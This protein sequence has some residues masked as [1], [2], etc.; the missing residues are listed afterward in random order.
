MATDTLIAPYGAGTPISAMA[1]PHIDETLRRETA[2]MPPIDLRRDQLSLLEL[3]LNGGLSPLPGYMGSAECASVLSQYR[4]LNGTFWPLPVLLDV[5]EQAVKSIAAGA[6]VALRDPEGF[7]LAILDVEEVWAPTA[8]Q[9]AVMH[10]GLAEAGRP[11]AASAFERRGTHFVSG[12]LTGLSVPVR[13]DFPGLR[14]TPEE[15]RRSFQKRGWRRVVAFQIHNTVHRVQFEVSLR[16][17]MSL[18]ANLFL[19]LL[20]CDDPF[21]SPEY[22]PRVRSVQTVLSRYP[23]ASTALCLLPLSMPARDARA[24][25]LRAIVARNYGATHLIVGG[26][27]QREGAA[28][29]GVDL[30]AASAHGELARFSSEVGVEILPFPRMMYVEERAEYVREEEIPK[31]SRTLIM[32]G[33]EIERRLSGGLSIPEWAAFPEVIDELR[34]SRPPRNRR[35]FTV[36]FTGLSG[37]GKSTLARV[38]TTKLLEIGDRR[39]TLLDGD[40]VR[41]HLSNELGFSRAHRD[42]N[43]R[44]IGFVASEITKNNG[45]AICA[46]IAP[47][48]ETRR[49]VRDMIEP[50]GGFFEV[51][52]S[53]PLDVCE[54]R[55]RKGLYARA[56]AGLIPE[57]TGVSDPYELPANPEL[58][59]D[60]S[61][62]SVDAAVQRILLKLEQ[63]GYL[64]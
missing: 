56:R 25:L 6:R 28:R 30:M 53:T 58:A 22:F 52:V 40:I 44:R 18:E 11:G 54:S 57:F 15:T 23:A 34:R 63:E 3:L 36:F 8:E 47:Y 62:I 55:D 45:V 46:P 9:L 26:D 35:G 16:T 4:L 24:I 37:S 21:T 50:L 42:I 19:Q 49:A 48:A 39:V 13:H 32:S 61:N 33:K 43:I 60:T 10:S 12:R 14:W 20:D 17:A 64:R 5:A 27:H 51:H 31:G 29:R 59:I 7:A 1:P 41:R 2:V 38:L